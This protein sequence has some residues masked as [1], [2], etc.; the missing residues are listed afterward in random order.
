MNDLDP[1]PLYADQF[2][3]L[4]RDHPELTD[5]EIPFGVELEIGYTAVHSEDGPSVRSTP[6]TPLAPWGDTDAYD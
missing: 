1:S 5:L 2:D 4:L 6:A 3:D